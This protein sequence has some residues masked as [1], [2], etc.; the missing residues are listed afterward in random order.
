MV[1]SHDI[2]EHFQVSK[3]QFSKPQEEP[4]YSV[5]I[6]GYMWKQ[7]H[8]HLMFLAW[9]FPYQKFPQRS[10]IN[11]RISALTLNLTCPHPGAANR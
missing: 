5:E 9:F 7:T 6:M 3:N 10:W 4:T 2:Y 11:P 8:Y 1:L